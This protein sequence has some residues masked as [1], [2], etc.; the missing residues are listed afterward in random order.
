MLPIYEFGSEEQKQKYLPKLATGEYI[1]CFG[2]A[3]PDHG[4]DPG[5]MVTRAE[6]C[7]RRI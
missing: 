6:I 4:S 3:E 7:T 1:G 2:L 5:S